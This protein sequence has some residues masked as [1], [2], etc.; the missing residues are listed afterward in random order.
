[1]K[2]SGELT[3]LNHVVATVGMKLI[4]ATMEL[5]LCWNI[6][7]TVANEVVVD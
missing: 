2:T 1:M 6:V 7:A 5:G 3:L 4:V